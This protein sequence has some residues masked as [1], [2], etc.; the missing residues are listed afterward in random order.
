LV[1]DVSEDVAGHEA[2]GNLAHYYN[3]EV[4]SGPLAF[5]EVAVWYKDFARK[6]EIKPIRELGVLMLKQNTVPYPA[7]PQG[8][9]KLKIQMDDQHGI[10][11]QLLFIAS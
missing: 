5:V 8:T 4:I 3:R 2:R 11:S 10:V 6:M 9:L 1:V 7:S